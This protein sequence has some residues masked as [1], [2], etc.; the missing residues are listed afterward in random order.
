MAKF[1]IRRFLWMLPVALGVLTLVFFLIHLLPGDPVDMM[2]GENAPDVDRAALRSALHLDRPVLWQYGQFL[3]EIVRGNLGASFSTQQPVTQMIL[4]RYPAT[5][6]LAIAALLIALFIAIPLGILSAIRRDSLADHAILLFSLLG[7]SMPSFWIGPLLI[8]VFSLQLDMLPVS[9]R[10]GI[11]SLILPAFT[12][13][14]GMSAVLTQ[15]TR[16]SLLEVIHADFVLSAR[17]K[18]LPGRSV[19]LKHA[20]RCALIPIVTV[21]GLQVGALLTGTIITETIF[22]WP[23]LGRLTIQAIQ[24]RDYPLVQGCILFTVMTYLFVNLLVDIL[25]AKIDPRIG[26]GWN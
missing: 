5:L 26:L 6:E 22:S 9:G 19:I 2:L 24:S 23:G 20:F 1:L 25:Y 12:L 11:A 17:A 16:S 15:L 4:A 7:V 14:I 10:S 8:I 3:S 13:G 18:G 21:V